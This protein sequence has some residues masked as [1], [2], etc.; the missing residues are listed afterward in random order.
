MQ[1]SAHKKIPD[2]EKSEKSGKS[3]KLGESGGNRELY[4][5]ASV[6]ETQQTAEASHGLGVARIFAFVLAQLAG[7]AVEGP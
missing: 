5:G 2:P 4:S 7:A 3:G 1:N 6:V